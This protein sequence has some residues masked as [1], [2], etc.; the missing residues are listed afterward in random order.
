MRNLLDFSDVTYNWR[1]EI[2]KLTQMNKKKVVNPDAWLG[3]LFALDIEEFVEP[4]PPVL[5]ITEYDAQISFHSLSPDRA[6]DIV[7]TITVNIMQFESYDD[8]IA[9]VWN[10]YSGLFPTVLCENERVFDAIFSEDEFNAIREEYIRECNF[11]S[12]ADS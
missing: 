9:K 4:E 10:K 2:S 3:G 7:D 8:F 12:L 6:D 11:F 5:S 1:N